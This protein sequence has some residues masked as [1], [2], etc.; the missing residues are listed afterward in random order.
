MQSYSDK[1]WNWLNIALSYLI[2][3]IKFKVIRII[4][5]KNLVNWS[6][7]TTCLTFKQMLIIIR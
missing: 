2:K 7:I 3:F 4:K 6:I 1:K 5:I